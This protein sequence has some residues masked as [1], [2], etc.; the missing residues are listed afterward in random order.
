M[1]V[2]Q[3]ND[4][5]YEDIANIVSMYI[6][7]TEASPT[8]EAKLW[9][10]AWRAVN[11]LN[12]SINIFPRTVEL[13]VLANKTAK[14]PSDYIDWAKVGVL[15]GGRIRTI[16]HNQDLAILKSADAN[17]MSLLFGASDT[18]ASWP[19]QD[20]YTSY[21]SPFSRQGY[22]DSQYYS[23]SFSVDTD[24][25]SLVFDSN[26]QEESVVLQYVSAPPKSGPVYIP[27]VFREAVIAFIAW[28]DVYNMPSSTKAFGQDKMMRRR[29]YYNQRRLAIENWNKFREGQEKMLSTY[30]NRQ[31]IKG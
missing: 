30:N 29:E 11:D 4:L 6:D 2:R 21:D 27:A 8:R 17:R 28:R 1:D 26:W 20:G 12:F 19:Y 14:L 24:T 22:P 16:R 13:P 18:V 25:S 5:S 10:L 23:G 3:Q 15:D 9:V 31:V 7:E